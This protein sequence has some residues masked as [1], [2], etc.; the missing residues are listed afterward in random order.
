MARWQGSTINT[1]RNAPCLGEEILAWLL[2][3]VCNHQRTWKSTWG[4][5]KLPHRASRVKLEIWDHWH[6][7]WQMILEPLQVGCIDQK[8]SAFWMISH[9]Q[10]AW[11]SEEIYSHCAT[12]TKNELAAGCWLVPMRNWLPSMSFQM[13]DM[14]EVIHWSNSCLRQ[15]APKIAFS[16]L[17]KP[18]RLYD[19]L[20]NLE[21]WSNFQKYIA[22]VL[23]PVVLRVATSWRQLQGGA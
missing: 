21:F 3:L 10:K 9:I 16:F 18:F 14:W 23:H 5:P 20:D 13:E 8:R 6:W 19:W 2:R 12:S 22:Y 11:K 4:G 1:Q 7:H 15:V 17:E